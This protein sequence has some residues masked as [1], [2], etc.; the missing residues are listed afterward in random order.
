MSIQGLETLA[1]AMRA[2]VLARYLGVFCLSLVLIAAVPGFVA[3]LMGDIGFAVHCGIVSLLLAAVGFPLS[4]L[5]APSQ[6]QMNEAMAIISLGFL[7]GGAAMTLPFT[8]AGLAPIDAFFESVSAITTTG[9][10]AAGGTENKSDAFLFA[11]AWAQWYGGLG[12]IIL[13]FVIVLGP[14]AVSRRLTLSETGPEDL[15][16]GSWAHGKKVLVLYAGLTV[17]GGMLLWALGAPALDAVVHALSSLSTG[18]YSSYE[19]SAAGLEG[20]LL[21]G[22]LMLLCIAGAISFTLQYQ[23]W[24]KGPMSFFRDGEV[25]TLIFL[26]IAGW[27]LIL[28]AE[29]L[30]GRSLNAGLAGNAAF[31]T[32]SAQTTAGYQT[33]APTDLS[34]AS[35]LILIFSM[36]VGG[37]V[38]STAGGL[39]IFRL[40]IM[41][42]LVQVLLARTATPRHAVMEP[43]LGGRTLEPSEISTAGGMVALY[44]ATIFLSWL[45]FLAA[46]LDPLDSLF[47]VAS[48]VGTVG[49]STGIAGADL[50]A[51][52]KLI[53]TLDMLMGRLEILA[54]LVLAYPRNWIGP[55][56][57]NE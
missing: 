23:V 19:S 6:I 35:K 32:V 27:A 40:L 22:I 2:R 51:P 21:R 14:G 48:A 12:I 54:V 24:R 17:A 55:R 49:L 30:S 15:L 1:T 9:L 33:I 28:C 50:T 52:L 46:G 4:R 29:W 16:G 34:T 3:L 25:Q 13:A 42:R 36:T 45:C 47:D 11:R 43:R 31:M 18:G 37:D 7:I 56:R 39:K 53:L 41:I 57:G 38:G 8:A 10:S 44:A 5:Q 26:M 20:P